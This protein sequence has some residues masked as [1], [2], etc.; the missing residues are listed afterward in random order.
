MIK[1]TVGLDFKQ[2]VTNCYN[3]NNN[4]KIRY[5]M[6]SQP[7]VYIVNKGAHDYSDAEQYGDIVYCT[8]GL[9]GKFSTSQMVRQFSDVFK[10]STPDDYILL[11][12][13]TTLCSIAT[14]TFAVKHGRLNLLIFK[15]DR[16]VVRRVVF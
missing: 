7:K 2:G 11:T 16:Y 1:G 13:L 9:V 6:N 15:D 4:N 10:T 12:S 8:E 14:S 5:N 3:L